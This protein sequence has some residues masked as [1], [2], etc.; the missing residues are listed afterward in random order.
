MLEK[1]RAKYAMSEGGAG[2]LVVTVFAAGMISFVSSSVLLVGVFLWLGVMPRE[3]PGYLF[4]IC[5]C[6]G[7]VVGVVAAVFTWRSLLRVLPKVFPLGSTEPGERTGQPEA[8]LKYFEVARPSL[9]VAVCS[10]PECPCPERMLDCGS[11]YLWISKGLVEFRRNLRTIREVESRFAGHPTSFGPGVAAPIAMCEE[12]ARRRGLDFETAAGDFTHW[13]RTG[14]VPLRPTPLAGS[15]GA[16]EAARKALQEE[17]V[18]AKRLPSGAWYNRRTNPQQWSAVF[19]ALCHQ[20]E[21]GELRPQLWLLCQQ[22]S[23]AVVL[24][25]KPSESA[26]ALVAGVPEFVEFSDGAAAAIFPVANGGNVLKLLRALFAGD[27]GS[28][29]PVVLG[30]VAACAG[31]AGRCES[32][33]RDARAP[34]GV[35]DW[36]CRAMVIASGR[37]GD[38]HS[39]HKS[40]RAIRVV[41]GV[42]RHAPNT[43]E[44]AVVLQRL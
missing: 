7:I 12:A 41:I 31:T 1:T 32:D 3:A 18:A 33:S 4:D 11:G 27:Y 39:G 5:C 29:K 10:D 28:D 43:G 19:A 9:G 14:L 25:T 23:M 42:T 21:Q 8:A 37:T 16:V 20:D 13:W 34:G 2:C 38:R 35:G 26:A 6:V 17:A 36:Q 15:R 44:I 22:P 40:P 30:G 24:L